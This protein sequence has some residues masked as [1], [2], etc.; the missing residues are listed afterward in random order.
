MPFFKSEYAQER[1]SNGRTKGFGAKLLSSAYKA[2]LGEL[3]DEETRSHFKLPFGATWADL[4]ALQVAKRS[5][6]LISKEQVCFTAITELRE[7]TEGKTAEK[8]AVGGNSEL[9]ALAAA[10]SGEPAPLPGTTPES[11]E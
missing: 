5:V 7:T 8:I 10:L 6:G 11:E 2:T 9:D 3:V 1:K 4:I